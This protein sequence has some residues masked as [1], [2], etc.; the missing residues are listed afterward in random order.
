MDQVKVEVVETQVLQSLLASHLYVLF[1]VEGVPELG[2]HEQVRP[3]DDAL[4][5]GSL[6]SL[7][8]LLLVAVVCSLVDASVACFN[9]FV[10]SVSCGLF[11]DLP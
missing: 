10:S 8:A 4:V 3:G 2:S 1:P 9:G 11:G 6:D 5:N 7:A